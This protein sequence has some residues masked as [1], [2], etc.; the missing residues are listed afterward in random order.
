MGQWKKKNQPIKEPF[1]HVTKRMFDSE[2]Y[3][4]LTNASRVA[5]LLLRR[6]VN[7]KGQGEIVCPYSAALA[8]MNKN[9]FSRA[10]KQLIKLG[11]IEKQQMGGMFRRTNTYRF[12]DKWAEVKHARKK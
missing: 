6:Q 2:S 9:T 3:K 7:G 5:L 11:F 12:S 10:I 8:Y 4:Q 1:I